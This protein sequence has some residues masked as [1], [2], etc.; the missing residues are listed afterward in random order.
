MYN[1]DDLNKKTYINQV[2]PDSTFP[3]NKEGDDNNKVL[4][5][6]EIKIKVNEGDYV[7]VIA[8]KSKK[9][10]IYIAENSKK[11]PYRIMSLTDKQI[12]RL[13]NMKDMPGVKIIV[14]EKNYDTSVII[15]P[16]ESFEFDRVVLIDEVELEEENTYDVDVREYR[17]NK[18]SAVGDEYDIE[19][20]PRHHRKDKDGNE[21]P[22]EIELPHN[23]PYTETIVMQEDKPKS[24]DEPEMNL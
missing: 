18:N 9:V 5:H 24:T 23:I 16:D 1:K 4:E 10:I 12:K 22:L 13:K 6:R 15:E 19:Y 2:E 8:E 20:I 17:R 21:I 11:R 14:M 7:F 3:K